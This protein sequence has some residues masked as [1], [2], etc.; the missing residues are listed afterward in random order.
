MMVRVWPRMC[1]VLGAVT[2]AG[3][4]IAAFTPVSTMA[5]RR[6]SVAPDVG[7]AEAIVVLGASAYADGS[8]GDASLRRAVAGIRLYREGL[9]PR[10]VFL[11][12]VGEAEARARLAVSLGVPR[13]AIIAE[14]AEPTTRD[15]AYR[16]GVVLGQRLGV[17]KILLVTDVLHM[18]RARG[19]FERVGLTVRPA[20]TD[21]AALGATSPERRLALTRHV[22]QE[23]AALAY[24]KLFGYL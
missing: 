5:A 19:L 22:A 8:L 12:M 4:L 9:A 24:H 23:A 17:R 14:G 1:R 6:L 18:R 16:V 20:S 15:E 7:P 2:V 11:G 21:T 13:E 10:L 3:F